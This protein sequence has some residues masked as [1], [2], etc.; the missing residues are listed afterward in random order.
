MN[1]VI[2]KM[3]VLCPNK[4]KEI[5]Q[6]PSITGEKRTEADF[7]V[8]KIMHVSINLEQ[9]VLLITCDNYNLPDLSNKGTTMRGDKVFRTYT[10]IYMCTCMH[11][12]IHAY[13]W[14]YM[15]MCDM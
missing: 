2:I 13:I 10:Y 12:C 4:F 5:Y 15:Y 14:M 9:L 6:V 11:V 7:A 3:L 1:L 8:N